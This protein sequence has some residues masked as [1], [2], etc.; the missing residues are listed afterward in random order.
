MEQKRRH[1]LAEQGPPE[2]VG[3]QTR[4]ITVGEKTYW[5]QTAGE[6]M[7][8]VLLHGFTG[9]SKTWLPFFPAL[10][11]HFQV[12]AVDLPGHGQTVAPDDPE[13]YRMERVCD[14]LLAV[15]DELGIGVFHLLG[16]SMG[17]R[18]ALHVAL[19]APQRVRTLVL[20]SASPGIA[21][22]AERAARRRQ[23]EALAKQLEEKG[24]AWFV[25]YWENIPLFAS[26]KRLPA[27]VRQQIRQQRLA[28]RAQGL[29]C[30][31]RGMG[32][33]VQQALQDR[34][35][36]LGMPVLLL[37]GQLDDKYHRLAE[38][39]QTR[40]PRCCWVS[41]ADAGH[42]VHIE[43]PDVFTREVLSFLMNP[44]FFRA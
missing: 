4:T 7:P 36:E 25:S 41:V 31:L 22:E 33:G 38:W 43:K 44:S 40:I 37:T 23:D 3:L 10:A 2:P 30:S 14:D 6:G 24:Q 11:R 5:L 18:L 15:L 34:L 12:V 20:E 1:G 17:G 28:Q 8:L 35:P 42:A 26:Q 27:D 9:S 39:M 32:A 16:Y 29:A 19:A 13:G 21:D